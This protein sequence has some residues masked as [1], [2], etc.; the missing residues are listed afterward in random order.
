VQAVHVS[1][2]GLTPLKGTRHTSVDE[3]TLV[4]TG[5]VGDRV[6]CLVDLERRR[7]LRTVEHPSLLEVRSAWDGHTL[8]VV[9]PDGTTVRGAP[10]DDEQDAPHGRAELKADYWGRPATLALQAGP[11]AAVLSRY[12]GQDLRLARVAPGEVV[13]GGSVSIVTT[14]ALKELAAHAG[15]RR[16][17]RQDAR[18]RAT[19]T[20]ETEQDLDLLPAGARITLGRATVEVRG[21]IPRCAVVDLDPVTGL[22][23]APVLRTLAG[24][25]RG[26]GEV[27]FG[28][29]A[30]VVVPGGIRQGDPAAV[31]A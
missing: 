10:Y 22:Q 7:V 5:P 28:V 13:Y 14:A 26:S 4:A 11:H 6:F 21:P 8:G 27:C 3:A 16:L 30:R 18:F 12:L 19:V 9:L 20:L 23:T 1:R 25:R 17:G 2:V 24:Y 29:D 31:E 15:D